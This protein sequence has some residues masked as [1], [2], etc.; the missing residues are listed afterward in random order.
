MKESFIHWTKAICISFFCSLGIVLCLFVHLYDQKYPPT[1]KNYMVVTKVEERIDNIENNFIIG[2]EVESHIFLGT[3]ALDM[4]TVELEMVKI[5][6]DRYNSISKN[7]IVL[8]NITPPPET[9]TIDKYLFENIYT[10]LLMTTILGI[11][12]VIISSKPIADFLRRVGDKSFM[13][14]V[15]II[16]VF[17]GLSLF[18]IY[19]WRLIF[20]LKEANLS[21]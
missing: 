6:N 14:W 9:E 13:F 2:Y 15:K 21:I 3:R 8:I 18:S 17:I 7:E 5:P 16:L 11:I 20:L 4:D 19:F 1:V 12:G 10:F